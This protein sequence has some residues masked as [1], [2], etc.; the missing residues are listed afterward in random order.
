M[1]PNR[2]ATAVLLVAVSFAGTAGCN[3]SL[4][5]TSRL[6]RVDRTD[7]FRPSAYVSQDLG[8]SLSGD[9][10]EVTAGLNNAGSAAFTKNSPVPSGAHVAGFYN[11]GIPP[12]AL[13]YDFFNDPTADPQPIDRCRTTQKFH[14]T[15]AGGVNGAGMAAAIGVLDNTSVNRLGLVL[16]GKCVL[17]TLRPYGEPNQTSSDAV[18]INDFRIAVGTSYSPTFGPLATTW[19]DEV[20]AAV[21]LAGTGVPGL[22]SLGS[23]GTAINNKNDIVGY[24]LTGADVPTAVKTAWLKRGDGRV[25]VDIAPPDGDSVPHGIN[26]KTVVVGE[27]RAPGGLQAWVYQPDDGG[28]SYLPARATNEASAAHGVN[29]YGTVV[30]QCGGVACVWRVSFRSGRPVYNVRPSDLNGQTDR[31]DVTFT[32]ALR[33]NDSGALLVEGTVRATGEPRVFILRPRFEFR[34]RP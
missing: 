18:D 5:D 16:S 17:R 32:R 26:D 30:G 6:G 10:L 28:W 20:A 34:P 9:I 23:H 3:G 33:I 1:I 15:W 27:V 21:D 12:Q 13:S 4:L 8:P 19:R 31:P 25:I 24:F 22:G 29:T 14:S 7:I 11:Q 2:I